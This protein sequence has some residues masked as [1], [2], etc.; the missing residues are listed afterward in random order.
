MLKPSKPRTLLHVVGV[1]PNYVKASAVLHAAEELT[2]ARNLL[3]DTGQHYDASL[4]DAVYDDL[5]LRTPDLYLGVGSGSHAR[6][7]AAI[8]LAFEEVLL[9]VRP[10]VVVVFGDV[11]S[12]MACALVA[13]KMQVPLVH[14]EAG[15]RCFDRSMPEEINRI[16]TDSVSDLLFTPSPDADA[17]LLREG[18]PQERIRFVGNVMVD[19][20][21]RAL[22]RALGRDVWTRLSVKREGYA[23]LTLHRAQNVDT[24]AS[25][26]RVAEA[27]EQ[28][29]R[30]LPV[31]FPVH[32]RTRAS[33]D[34]MGVG[35]KLREM[36]NVIMTPPFGY[37]DFLCLEAHASVVLTD[38]GGVQEET[39]V[40]GVPCVTLLDR[41]ERPV[42]VTQGTNRLAS[43]SP[44]RI[45][46][47]FWAGNAKERRPATIEGWDGGAAQ[48]V[49]RQIE[50]WLR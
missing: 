4:R 10:D 44:E 1:R 2:S 21:H 42:T 38:S 34:S 20:L 45:L 24:E 27:I 14:V 12:T 9:E 35:A 43:T 41:T 18:A 23:L 5:G 16:V 36:P 33:L 28:I 22:P 49:V 3:V 13:A 25:L 29:Q 48:R 32:P 40:L 37:L 15:L 47:A 6:Q 50:A 8:M 7:T 11:N 17:N 19:A 31:V 30:E 39:S 46:E 26:L